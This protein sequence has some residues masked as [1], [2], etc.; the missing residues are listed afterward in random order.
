MSASIFSETVCHLGEGPSYDPATESLFWFDILG[1]KL[2]EKPVSGGAERVHDL[3]ELASAVAGVDGGRQLLVTETGLYLRDRKSGALT[4]HTPL[5]A[6]NAGTRSNDARTH[7]SGTFWIGTMGKKA[8]PR[9][10]AIYWFRKGELRKIVSD[11]TIPNAICFAPDGRTAYFT[12]TVKN[13]LFRVD[14][15]PETGLPRGEP[16]IFADCRGREGGPDGAVV[17][18]EG[19]VWNARW[20]AG[21]VDA[22]SPDGALIRTVAVPARQS[23]CPAFVRPRADRL[24]VTSAWEG[25]DEAARAADPHAGKTFLLDIPVK[26]RFEPPVLL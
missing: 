4:L 8:E 9:A 25:M 22:Y 18:A 21:A 15:D 11:V 5:E 13:V 7:P 10:G 24:V 12:G 14:C 23:S 2:L 19:V 3:P 16:K 26:G 17:D 6:D 20:G 1:R